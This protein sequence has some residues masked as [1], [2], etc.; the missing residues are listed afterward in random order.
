EVVRTCEPSTRN[1]AYQRVGRHGLMSKKITTLT[2]AQM[3]RMPEWVDK[4]VAIGLSTEPANFDEAEKGVRG[5]YASAGLAQP[6]VVLRM[7]SPYGAVVGGAMAVLLLGGED[8]RSQVWSQV[9]R[10]VWSQI[11][12]QV[13]SQVD[14][15]VA[16]QAW[17][18]VWSQV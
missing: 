8:V 10:Q 3:A 12:S 6:T 9:E 11:R 7:S 5:C 17:S 14:S 16:S 1:L 15:Q 13:D 18:Q 4:W 2:D